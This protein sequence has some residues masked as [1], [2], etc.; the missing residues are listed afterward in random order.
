[1][2]GLTAIAKSNE[3]TNEY[4][5]GN[6]F[7]SKTLEKILNVLEDSSKQNTLNENSA[8]RETA[9]EA[10]AK[11][12]KINSSLKTGAKNV[13]DIKS[14]A[15]DRIGSVVICATLD[16]GFKDVVNALKL[17]TR[18][19]SSTRDIKKGGKSL[20]IVHL[21]IPELRMPK[22]FEKAVSMLKS[23]PSMVAKPFRGIANAITAP[24]K[25]IKGFFTQAFDKVKGFF[26]SI[27]KLFGSL[28]G[29]VKNF[30]GKIFSNK[31]SKA[32]G[33]GDIRSVAIIAGDAIAAGQYIKNFNQITK[34][35]SKLKPLDTKRLEKSGASIK[36]W[37]ESLNKDI[38]ALK[39]DVGVIEDFSKKI[40]ATVKTLDSINFSIIKAAPLTAIVNAMYG[41]NKDYFKGVMHYAMSLEKIASHKDIDIRGIQATAS[42]IKSTSGSLASAMATMIIGKPLSLTIN[43]LYGDDRKNYFKGIVNWLKSA[44]KMGD[45]VSKI[46]VGDISK[47]VGAV[48][49]IA[50]SINEI[51]KTITKNIAAGIILALKVNMM[52]FAGIHTWLWK[53]RYA[54]AG[55][56]VKT[57]AAMQIKAK[58]VADIAK[59]LKQISVDVLLSYI[60][61][62]IL[63]K[64]FPNAKS[65]VFN[66]IANWAEALDKSLIQNRN[67]PNAAKS[68]KVATSM[69][70]CAAVAKSVSSFAFAALKMS[71]SLM[72]IGGVIQKLE[73]K[74]VRSLNSLVNITNSIGNLTDKMQKLKIGKVSQATAVTLLLIPYFTALIV[75]F[76]PMALA[77][78][79]AVKINKLNPD[80]AFTALTKS[81]STMLMRLSNL[82]KELGWGILT[83]G[84]LIVFSTLLLT[85]TTLLTLSLPLVLTASLGLVA[86]AGMFLALMLVSM[87]AKQCLVG[88]LIVAACSLLLAVVGISL[89]VAVKSL[90][91]VA[92]LV[93]KNFKTLLKGFGELI[94][95]F[96]ALALAGAASALAA[97]T[98]PA[99]L[100]NAALLLPVSIILSKALTK[101]IEMPSPDGLA[102]KVLGLALVFLA[103]VPA[104]VA[105]AAGAAAAVVM[106]VSLFLIGDTMVNAFK[107]IQNA[108]DAAKNVDSKALDAGVA[109]IQNLTNNIRSFDFSILK[110]KFKEI[111]KGL[112]AAPSVKD[113]K[114]FADSIN[115]LGTIDMGLVSNFTS[116]FNAQFSSLVDS[117]NV[118][119][120][121]SA[122]IHSLSAELKN[123]SKQ[124]DAIKILKDIKS[125][126]GSASGF[127][128]DIKAKLAGASNK[129]ASQTPSS[130]KTVD[131]LYD[132]LSQINNKIEEKKAPSWNS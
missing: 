18:N 127:V 50:K 125:N 129:G 90:S 66:G 76:I 4:L 45:A 62:K 54:L 2:D 20:P 130:G 39:L 1:M 126:S 92:D 64:L 65:D 42:A 28:F 27:P 43:T 68:M 6:S 46:K 95:V 69:K 113:T 11:N 89:Y 14:D 32:G 104:S 44:K 128:S 80:D 26:G 85:A 121:L 5:S 70:A 24:F 87:V 10:I 72:L 107:V 56:N 71:I 105:A 123:V 119:D 52:T 21:R 97:A 131:D 38:L 106:K 93:V 118:I 77:A 63:N 33:K 13:A 58:A 99:M 30:F 115:V 8:F 7:I 60:P 82:K 47:S 17:Q 3:K 57:I 98:L 75:A 109:S 25:S 40:K 114:K 34:Q 112:S 41:K 67:F 36:K 23:I 100:I 101:L 15:S 110:K 55:L 84:L 116:S 35:I 9:E 37:T 117:K 83:L 12:K 16:K 51:Q 91:K 48:N 102:S 132:L 61:M 79:I 53:V 88:I 49:N 59:S 86:A 78:R 94:L 73:S 31:D 124:K 111:D 108:S 122:S 29:G 22:S 96:G 103:L 81:L 19:A 74:A 120:S